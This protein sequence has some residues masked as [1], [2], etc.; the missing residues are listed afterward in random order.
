MKHRIDIPEGHIVN[1]KIIEDPD[2]PKVLEV[3]FEEKT[4]TKEPSFIHK[5]SELINGKGKQTS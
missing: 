2:L 3:S 4:E 5:V 1:I